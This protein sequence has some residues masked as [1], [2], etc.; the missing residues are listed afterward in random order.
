MNLFDIT[1]AIEA[2]LGSHPRKANDSEIAAYIQ[3]KRERLGLP[4]MGETRL[5]FHESRNG[6]R[7]ERGHCIGATFGKQPERGT[8]E[9]G[10]YSII[11]PGHDAHRARVTMET[12]CEAGE[13]V[14]S[15]TLPVEPKK[16]GVIWTRDD[17]RKAAGPIAK[18]AK[19]KAA[20]AM[21]QI[22][23][24]ERAGEAKEPCAALDGGEAPD[25]LSEAPAGNLGFFV[26]DTGTTPERA[27]SYHADHKAA[28]A[29]RD[30][31]EPVAT[32]PGERRTTGKV[33]RYMV[34][35]ETGPI[36]CRADLRAVT[37]GYHAD[38]AALTSAPIAEPAP[39]P[40]AIA[41]LVARIEALESALRYV[42]PALTP[43]QAINASE[44]AYLDDMLAAPLS[45]EAGPAP[46]VAKRTP[47]HERAIRRAWAERKARR[48]VQEVSA[49]RLREIITLSQGKQELLDTMHEN[50]AALGR[51]AENE[52][53]R[54]DQ[55]ARLITR[56]NKQ[57]RRVLGL[58]LEL[59]RRGA[60]D[61]SALAAASDYAR[62]LERERDFERGR[63][64][65]LHAQL[66]K[67]A[68]DTA[69]YRE[70]ARPGVSRF[71]GGASPVALRVVA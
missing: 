55:N 63:A 13:V 16:C 27:L 54:A 25:A 64:D 56:R 71:M 67:I 18:P 36:D 24:Q 48:R 35:S 47:A 68:A 22:S 43:S 28:M 9:N 59:R 6:R 69:D 11:M 46:T 66:A 58:A 34:V 20:P 52:T 15:Q 51:F 65:T 49:V 32:Y 60:L 7:Y 26:I 38:I 39:E 19:G 57:R 40:D 45:A 31:L 44:L 41:A 62:K 37:L 1:R 50:Y 10:A 8:W 17:V 2:P 14:A 21:P 4:D 5:H 70:R 30:A 3:C 23:G 61:R 29:A 33:W 12:L 53:L 42:R